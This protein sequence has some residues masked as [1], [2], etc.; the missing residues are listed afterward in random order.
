MI[1]ISDSSDSSTAGFSRDL[2]ISF[3]LGFIRYCYVGRTFN[4][5]EKTARDRVVRANFNPVTGV[6]W[7]KRVAVVD[8]SIVRGSTMKKLVYMHKNRVSKEHARRSARLPFD[9]RTEPL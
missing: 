6:P 7:G 5:P 2:G 1:G 3:E 8:D 4:R 9:N